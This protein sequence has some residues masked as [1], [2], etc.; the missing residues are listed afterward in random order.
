MILT[1]IFIELPSFFAGAI[2]GGLIFF[3]TQKRKGSK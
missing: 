1:T 2:M 3:Y